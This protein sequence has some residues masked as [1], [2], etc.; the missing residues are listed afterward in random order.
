MTEP[1]LSA[2]AS[3]Y[4]GRGYRVPFWRD[5]DDKPM[6]VP[7]VTTALDGIAK[8][9][10][11]QWAADQVSAYAVTHIDDLLSRTEEAG[12]GYL[13][14]F[15]KQRQDFQPLDDD[16]LRNA[17]RTVLNDAADLGTRMHEYVEADLIG[18]PLPEVTSFAMAEMVEEWNRFKSEHW[19]EPILNE[20]TFVNRSAGYAG[21]AD[22]VIRIDG[23]T[24]CLDEKT[25]RN[26][27][28]EHRA[29]LAALGAC[30]EYAEP[31][32]YDDPDG[33][34]YV[35]KAPEDWAE[36]HSRIESKFKVGWRAAPD[37]DGKVT[38]YWRSSPVPAFEKYALLHIRPSDT[39]N[40]GNYIAPF[41]NLIEVPT[42]DMD[43]Y[44]DLFL[45]GLAVRKAQRRIKQI[46]KED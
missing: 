46:G 38:T 4:G 16:N 12:F 17:H 35:R 21:T 24:Y 23:V 26:T 1:F 29:Q 5:A 28:P 3:G 36:L 42:V 41:C 44:Y 27:W 7:G 2:A 13:R 11:Q 30:D 6:L 43:A 9:M 45:A 22:M 40:N 20:A 33:F 34:E 19:L 39:D 8:P 37:K 18:R 31:T 10:L 32:T 14:Y 15:W 25:A